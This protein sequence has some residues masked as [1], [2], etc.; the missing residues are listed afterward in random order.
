MSLS[1]F[2]DQIS[3]IIQNTFGFVNKCQYKMFSWMDVIGYY[4]NSSLTK[5]NKSKCAYP[6]KL[7]N[8]S[9]SKKRPDIFIDTNIVRRFKSVD[10]ENSI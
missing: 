3:L 5:K 8:T 4:V 1:V 10:L 2:Y 9:Y 6:K 7:K